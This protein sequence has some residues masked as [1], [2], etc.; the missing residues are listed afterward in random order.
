M[1][2]LS[3]QTL[4]QPV[5]HGVLLHPQNRC[6][7]LLASQT[8]HRFGAEPGIR[9]QII[10][11]DSG[12]LRPADPGALKILQKS[13]R[14]TSGDEAVSDSFEMVA[15]EWFD[16]YK[17]NWRENHSSKVIARLNNDVFSWGFAFFI[18]SSV[19]AITSPQY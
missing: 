18:S 14:K 10:R 4:G 13:V 9:Q 1:D 12:A 8:D 17:S 5:F 11:F 16:R 7:Q 2:C 3:L 19:S 15:R 6:Q